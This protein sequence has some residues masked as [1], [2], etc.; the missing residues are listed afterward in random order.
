MTVPSVLVLDLGGVVGRWLPD[1]RLHRLAQLSGQSVAVVDQ[2]VFE[3]GFEEASERGRFDHETFVAELAGLLG[4][5]PGPTTD[6]ALRSAW[7]LAWEP[8]P[9]VMRIVTSSP[10]RT[11]LFTNN[12]PLVEAALATELAPV[13]AAFDEL[14]LSWRLGVAKPETEAFALATERLG[15][16]PSDVWFA[17]DSE[18]NV[19]A[20]R[21]FGWHAHRYTTA[22]DLQ[23]ALPRP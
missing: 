21:A 17:D 10:L 23:V 13:G 15:V 8:D 14:L 11:A 5:V 20:A 3:S 16:A 12:G 18:A 6:T 22:L 19:A 4:L 7:A 1:R 2:L 9:A